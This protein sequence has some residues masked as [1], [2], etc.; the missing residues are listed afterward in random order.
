MAPASRGLA[1]PGWPCGRGFPGFFIPWPTRPEPGPWPDSPRLSGQALAP[2]NPGLARF[3]MQGLYGDLSRLLRVIFVTCISF[4]ISTK[5]SEEIF[6]GTFCCFHARLFGLKNAGVFSKC[7]PSN[8]SFCILKFFVF[9]SVAHFWAKNCLKK[10][11][12]KS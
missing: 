10:S 7:F 8:I 3:L 2:A 1:R 9:P 12:A 6:A 5:K 4:P 11:Q